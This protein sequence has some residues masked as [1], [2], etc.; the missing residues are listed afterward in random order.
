MAPQMSEERDLL[1]GG[2]EIC[3]FLNTLSA[4]QFTLNHTYRLISA[5]RI[6]ARRSGPRVL[7]ASKRAIRAALLDA[8]IAGEAA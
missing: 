6:P 2:P 5:G 3:A 1:Y 7:I 4:R 8:F